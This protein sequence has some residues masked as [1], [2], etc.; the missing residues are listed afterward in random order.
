M[1]HHIDRVKF[2]MSEESARIISNGR[3]VCH[4]NFSRMLDSHFCIISIT[5]GQTSTARAMPFRT[6]FTVEMSFARN[7]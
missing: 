3:V 2:L 4:E 6:A 7:A 1:E 5:S